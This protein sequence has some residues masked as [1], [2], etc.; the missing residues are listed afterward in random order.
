MR[1][2]ALQHGSQFIGHCQAETKLAIQLRIEPNEFD[3]LRKKREEV[4]RERQVD[5]ER[6]LNY[7]AAFVQRN[8][9]VQSFL[10]TR[11]QTETSSS[12]QQ[13]SEGQRLGH[14]DQSVHYTAVRDM[15]GIHRGRIAESQRWVR[16]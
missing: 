14:A 11:A 15:A 10:R 5:R 8:R 4:A 12:L 6:H 13:Q 1:S 2:S 9:S 3:D 7:E 16:S